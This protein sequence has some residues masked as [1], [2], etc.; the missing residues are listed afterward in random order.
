MR[1][2]L[3]PPLKEAEM[4]TEFWRTGTG[5]IFYEHQLPALVEA[6]CKISRTLE[7]IAKLLD[8]TPLVADRIQAEAL[9][10]SLKKHIAEC[11]PIWHHSAVPREKE[12]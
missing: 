10:Q 4:E 5:R 3:P 9:G 7:Q 8:N 1:M 11:K 2:M 12:E 6:L